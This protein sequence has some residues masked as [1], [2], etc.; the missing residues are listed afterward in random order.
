MKTNRLA[1]AIG[2]ID[3]DLIEQAVNS[4]TDAVRTTERKESVQRRTWPAYSSVA[5]CLCVAA[6]TAFIVAVV[7]KA[8]IFRK[9]PAEVPATPGEDTVIDYPIDSDAVLILSEGTVIGGRRVEFQRVGNVLFNHG[10]GGIGN[11]NA[12]DYAGLAGELAFTSEDGSEWFHIKGSDKLAAVICKKDGE[13]SFWAF[14]DFYPYDYPYA[15]VLDKIYTVRSA[16]DVL[17]IVVNPSLSDMTPEGQKLQKQIGTLAITDDK[18]VER[19]YNILMSMERTTDII[20]DAGPE[21]VKANR[22]L[23]IELSG[24][25]NITPLKYDAINGRFYESGSIVYSVLSAEDRAWLESVMNISYN[26]E[27]LL[28]TPSPTP[29]P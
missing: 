22:Y 24:G 6:A 18:S 4:G 27:N 12:E 26:P 2:N 3:N 16:D 20:V 7:W 29:L 15:E 1:E 25:T 13:Y 11:G 9:N 19:F 21:S 8:G 5:A 23:T 14:Y 28:P 10:E 17:R